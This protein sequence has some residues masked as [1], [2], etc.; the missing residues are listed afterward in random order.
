MSLHRLASGVLLPGF[1]GTTAP[2]WLLKRVA[3]GLGGVVLFG[4]NVVAGTAEETDAQVTALNAQ[5]RGARADVVIG[6]DEEGG[7]VTRLDYGRGS[8]VPG[9]HALGAA[10]DLGLTREVAAS[11]GS[12]LAACGVSL[13]LAPSADLVLTLDDPVI[14][15][16][17][18]GSDPVAAG[19][20]VAAFVEGMQA[21]GVAACAKHFP[22]HGASTVDSHAALPVLPRSAA[23]LAAVEFVPFRAAVQAGVRSVMTGHLVVPEWGP[24]P[25]TLNPR[26]L[27]VLREDLGFT[28]AVITDGLDMKAVGG[29][30]A[31]GSVRALVAGVDAL[32][33]GGEPLDDD[34]LR[35]LVDS[36]VAAVESGVLPR[37]RL[38]EA[39]RRTAALGTP[40]SSVDGHDPS[41]GLK[42]ARA[43]LEVRGDLRV[44]GA[45][46][47]LD[48]AVE[49]S[50]AVG[51]VPWGLGPY[52]SELV[53]GTTVL[54]PSSSADE[55]AAV[56]SGRTV[57]V[58]TREA[59]RHAWARDLVSALVKIGLDL[60]HVE[61]GVPGP[62]LGTAARV[63]THGG[64][65]VCLR[66]AAE[67]IA[68]AG[69]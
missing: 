21:V 32:C 27:R 14:G 67:R 63:D 17:S 64:S 8:E 22:G 66:A 6:I 54:P 47:V 4:R 10:G 11:I 5:L 15:V 62:D 18:F 31:E 19:A 29:D 38:E 2:D 58:V 41:L 50:I 51:D 24:E 56:A 35:W 65:R 1:H 55:V 68:A 3:D 7:D 52:L 39:A 57:V 69:T 34:G 23:E 40:P 43:A 45:P 12:R 36:I 59:H 37:E 28:G 49:A 16:R 60:V 26:A 46:V 33:L 30:L 20:H 48:L 61:T 13:N 25:A 42:A 53:P 44:S 9:N